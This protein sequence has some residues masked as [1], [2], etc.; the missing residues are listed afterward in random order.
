MAGTHARRWYHR[1]AVATLVIAMTAATGVTGI[2]ADASAAPVPRPVNDDF[3]NATV[4]T[5]ATGGPI[6]GS[7]VGATHESGEPGS[8][9][10]VWWRYTSPVDSAVTLSSNGSEGDTKLAVYTGTW[11][12]RLTMS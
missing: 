11:T 4:W 7:T 3:A 2:G 5:A 8:G 1:G 12:S 10:S 6:V 9:P